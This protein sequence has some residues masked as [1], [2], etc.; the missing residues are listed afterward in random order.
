[1]YAGLCSN[2]RDSLRGLEHKHGHGGATTAASVASLA[3]LHALS[4]NTLSIARLHHQT[5][6]ICPSTQTP[7]ERPDSLAFLRP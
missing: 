6:G 7:T 3:V 2:G 5:L 4:Y 1:M